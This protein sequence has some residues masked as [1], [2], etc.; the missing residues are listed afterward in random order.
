MPDNPPK[1]PIRYLYKF[2][3]A[4][5]TEKDF[6]VLL[7]AQTLELM[8]QHRTPNPAWTKLDYFQC[9]NCPLGKEVEYCPVAVNL[10]RLV[11]SFKDAV[12]T[13]TT[14][15]TVQT[16]ERVYARQTTLHKGLSSIIGIYMVTSNCPVM[17][18]LRPNVRFH[19]P[20]ATREET[21]YRAIGMYLMAQYFL[22]RKGDKPDWELKHFAEVYQAV[23]KVNEGF[24]KRVAHASIEDASVNAVIILSSFGQALDSFLEDSLAE[25]AYLF[26]RGP[27]A[28]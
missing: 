8:S 24:S 5:G 12:S 18:K 15:V 1:P 17:D 21:I 11:E 28:E 19:L 9:E 4:N 16:A 22:M 20:F 23:S 7:D 2:R 13:E 25:I 26:N 27:T 14:N 6:E 10:S 3:F